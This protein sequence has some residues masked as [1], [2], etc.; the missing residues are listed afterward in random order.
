[1]SEGE[2]VAV[3]R[4]AGHQGVW[5]NDGAYMEFQVDLVHCLRNLVNN[6]CDREHLEE[7]ENIF[8]FL[9]DYGSR[10]LRPNPH[11][12]LEEGSVGPMEVLVVV[13]KDHCHSAEAKEPD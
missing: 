4:E 1:M 3:P 9:L 7:A 10:N 6:R 2:V 5:T 13:S 11:A 8:P 12:V